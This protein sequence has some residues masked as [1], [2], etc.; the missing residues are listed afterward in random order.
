[1]T[2][3]ALQQRIAAY[4]TGYN[5]SRGDP[6]GLP[7]YPAGE[8]ESRQHR[9]WIVLYKAISRFR[10]RRAALPTPPE[11]AAALEAQDGHC[12]I[13]LAQ[14]GAEGQIAQQ[15]GPGATMTIVHAEC[16]D[17]LSFVLKLGPSVLDRLRSY[18]WPGPRS[19]SKRAGPTGSRR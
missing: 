9:D 8:R 12:P 15:P 3:E 4:C 1:M 7:P 16:D 14:V 13:C 11:R 2:Q 19:S 18:A 17:L 5:V 10:Q 6:E